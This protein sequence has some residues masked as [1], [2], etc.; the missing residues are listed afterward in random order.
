[1][2]RLP[3]LEEIARRWSEVEPILK[4]AT[5][6]TDGC[7]APIHVLQEIMAGKR[8][9]WL[10]EDAG[11]LLG[12]SVAGMEVFPTGKRLWRVVYI[13]GDRAEEWYPSLI[14]EMEAEARKWQ[15]HALTAQGRLGCKR[16]RIGVLPAA[17]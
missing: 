17:R 1:V 13:A 11:A 12:V 3:P 4:R 7:F 2:I 14:A 5:D 15:C 8:A 9:L 10:V 6:T 16:Q